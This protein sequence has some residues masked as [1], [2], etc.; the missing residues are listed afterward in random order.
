MSWA[1]CRSFSASVAVGF[2][3]AERL[4]ELRASLVQRD[5]DGIVSNLQRLGD[6]GVAHLGEVAEGE[7]RGLA[8]G[9]VADRRA[10]APGQFAFEKGGIRR[11]GGG[12]RTEI[13]RWC[14][15][16]RAQAVNGAAGDEPPQQA[17]PIIDGL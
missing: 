1:A 4:L 5:R 7:D 14:R 8:V 9:E 11:L 3:Q 15:P 6:F 16:P 12:G 13:E 17:A 2:F 10:E